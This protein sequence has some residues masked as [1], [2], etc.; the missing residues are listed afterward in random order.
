MKMLFFVMACSGLEIQ[1]NFFKILEIPRACQAKENPTIFFRDSREFRDF[2]DSRDSSCENT[3]F[4][5]TPFSVHEHSGHY[6]RDWSEYVNVIGVISE[7]VAC[8]FR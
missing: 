1:N 3:S 4:V 7:P 5:V 6:S 8:E 2:R